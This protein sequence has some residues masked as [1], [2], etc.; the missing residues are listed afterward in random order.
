MKTLQ[1]E[2]VSLNNA[3]TAHVKVTRVWQHPLYKK[4]VRESNRF[5]C[6][7]EDMKLE[8]GDLVTIAECK[9]LSATKKFKV[10]EKT[11]KVLKIAID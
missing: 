5:A 1:G 2:V 7:Y 9:P 8:V 3:K 4:S 10:V 6:H 11:G